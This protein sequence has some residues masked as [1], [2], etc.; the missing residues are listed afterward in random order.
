MSAIMRTLTP[1]TAALALILALVLFVG[2]PMNAYAAE[3]VSDTQTEETEAIDDS[4][5]SGSNAST[6][7]T[8]T[9]KTAGTTKASTPKTGDTVAYVIPLCV[10]AVA[11][12]GAGIALRGKSRK[13]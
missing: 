7:T 4:S 8:G 11:A 10:A 1:I 13:E 5:A 2:V 6:K 12:I 9:T 3:Q